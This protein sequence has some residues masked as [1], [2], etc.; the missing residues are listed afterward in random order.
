MA[1]KTEKMK[2]NTL[3]TLFLTALIL[4]LCARGTNAVRTNELVETS[5]LFEIENVSRN[6]ARNLDKI[7]FTEGFMKVETR[8]ALQ[9]LVTWAKENKYP[10]LSEFLDV[11]SE[12]DIRTLF[13]VFQK[14]QPIVSTTLAPVVEPF[15]ITGQATP[16]GFPF[17]GEFYVIQGNSG[18][19]SHQR[20]TRNE[21]AWD[22][23][24]IKNGS[25]FKNSSH[26]NSNY[27]S[28][29]EPVISPAD[30]R[31]V[32]VRSNMPDHPPLTT[33]MQGANYI[34]IEHRN[35]ETSVIYHLM[36]GSVKITSGQDVAQGLKIASVG[37]SGISMFPH[38]HFELDRRDHDKYIP[39]PARFATY[40]SRKENEQDW[41]LVIS[42]IP[43][44]G[45]YLLSVDDFIENGPMQ[46]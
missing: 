9:R 12:N 8:N 34:F 4:I 5:L 3:T 24:V 17:K 42:G 15:E 37:N 16:L 36:N 33:K 45:E 39:G 14:G 38:I 7:V 43:Q 46:R 10:R 20:N 35:R 2:K 30:G 25:M 21:F 27:L 1:T 13:D 6:F 44:V 26:K 22:F 32:E 28:W 19:V 40:F 23:V 41:K 18:N 31:I 29:G 11:L